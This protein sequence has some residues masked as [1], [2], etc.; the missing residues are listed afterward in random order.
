MAAAQD[1]DLASPQTDCAVAVATVT[2]GRVVPSVVTS[3]HQLHGAI[4]VT[5][6]HRLWLATMR[7]RS[8]IGEFGGTARWSHRLGLM[9]LS[10]ADP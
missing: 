5:V 10:G 9:A 1:Y 2:L 3:A 8:W 7:A 6:E 4:G